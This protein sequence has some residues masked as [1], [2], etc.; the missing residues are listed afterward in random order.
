MDSILNYEEKYTESDAIKIYEYND[1]QLM[2]GSNLNI[3]ANINIHIENH[4]EFYH[5]RQSY[6]LV[7]GNLLKM[8]HG[9]QLQ[10]QQPEQ[11]MV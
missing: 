4:D 8:E 2:I 1:Y 5:R 10:M 3:P 9:T 7:E 11:I 6:L